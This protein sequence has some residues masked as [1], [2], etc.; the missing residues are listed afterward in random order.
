MQQLWTKAALLDHA[1]Y[2]KVLPA[3]AFDISC[4]H[5]Q[6]SLCY[7]YCFP[8]NVRPP[9]ISLCLCLG[10]SAVQCV[11]YFCLAYCSHMFWDVFW[12]WRGLNMSINILLNLL[13]SL[14][15][16]CT[17]WK[18]L[19]MPALIV[20]WFPSLFPFETEIQLLTCG[21]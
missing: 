18:K 7:E 13:K 21:A 5:T 17:E 20:H 6:Y 10:S 4:G 19:L 11:A 9:E 15:K 2:T 12:F 14:V 8:V 1:A 3:Q 16:N